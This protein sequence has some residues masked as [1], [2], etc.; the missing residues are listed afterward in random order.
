MLIKRS[1]QDILKDYN[2]NPFFRAKVNVI[3]KN[4]TVT[5]PKASKENQASDALLQTFKHSKK[6]LNHEL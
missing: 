3:L 4:S 5:S 6:S 1:N 2:S